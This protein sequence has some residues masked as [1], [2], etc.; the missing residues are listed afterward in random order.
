MNIPDEMERWKLVV[1][2]Y[3]TAEF[4]IKELALISKKAAQTYKYSILTHGLADKHESVA[5]HVKDI[6]MTRHFGPNLEL[7]KFAKFVFK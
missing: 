7:Q 1:Q 4:F 6:F 3:P 2:Y 5:G